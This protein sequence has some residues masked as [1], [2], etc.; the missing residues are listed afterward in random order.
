MYIYLDLAFLLNFLFDAE[1]IFLTHVFLSKK[2]AYSR[3]VFA[4]FL[5]GL[6][7]V[8]VFF[9]YFRILSL[10]P[11]SFLA[12]LFMVII[13]VK[14]VSAREAFEGY[15]FFLTAAFLIGGAMAFLKLKIIFGLFLILPLYMAI[16]NIKKR[17]FKKHTSVT[18]CYKGR[19]IEKNAV[20]DS[21]NTV[22]YYGKPVIFGNK[23]IF[24]EIL[25]KKNEVG[26]ILSEI[27][28]EDLC[29]VSYK[30]VDRNGIA[31][32]IRLE[33]AVVSGKSFEG[34]VICLFEGGLK[35]EIILNGIMA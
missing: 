7:G 19:K 27:N 8:F 22:S 25:D 24:F 34:T 29:I 6:E 14:P 23:T 15:I 4:A 16:L 18:L 21:G 3:M 10:P 9:P 12:A 33:N 11:V 32:G 17:I 1:I 26:G 31:A 28:K 13:A 20:Y 5:G 30:T 35:D 2:V